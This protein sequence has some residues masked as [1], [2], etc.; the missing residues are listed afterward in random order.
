MADIDADVQVLKL[1]LRLVL[2]LT[3]MRLKQTLKRVKKL[4]LTM[5]VK[6][7]TRTALAQRASQTERTLSSLRRG[8]GTE[9]RERELVV[10]SVIHFVSLS[11]NI[12]PMCIIVKSAINRTSRDMVAL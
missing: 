10:A 12:R 11:G 3:L 9:F 1:P 2:K 6:L 5:T 4:V 8:G 7:E